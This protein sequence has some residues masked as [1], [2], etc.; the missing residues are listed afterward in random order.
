MRYP[1]RLQRLHGFLKKLRIPFKVT[2]IFMGIASTVWFLVR[3]IPK[4]TRATYPCMQAAAP[5]MSGFIVYLI[6]LFSSAMAFKLLKKNIRRL[7]FIPA[8]L[9]LLIA[10]VSSVIFIGNNTSKARADI[11]IPVAIHTPNEPMGE[12][13]GIFPGRVVWAWD[14]DATN[15]NCSPTTFGDGWWLPK[16]NDQA[17]V[18]EMLEKSILKLTGESTIASAWEVLFKYFNKKK[19][20]QEVS[21]T[22]GEKILI[23]TNVTSAWS[24]GTSWAMMNSDFSKNFN[25][26]Y[27]IA[28]TSPH[29]VLAI[30]RQLV[31][32][33]G[34]K[35]EDISIGDPMKNIYQS[36]YTMWHDEFP[37]IH[38]LGNYYH[39]DFTELDLLN[40]GR[41]PV[42]EGEYPSIFY[43]DD[44]TITAGSDHFYTVTEDANYMINIPT[45]KAHA[46]AG[47]TLTAKNHFGSHTRSSAGHLH[48]GL[49]APDEGPPVRTDYGMYRT[50]V[51]L[52]GHPLLGG[53]T[54]L[55]IVD[56][57]YA[58]SEAIDPPTKWD[59]APFNGDWTSSVFLSQDQVAL[60]SVCFDFL[61]TEYDGTGGKVNYPNYPAVDDYLM[62]AADPA[63]WPEGIDYMPDGEN[64]ISSLGAHEHWNN[65]QDKAYTR[66]LGGNEGIQL[67]S[68]PGNLVTSDAG[69]TEVDLNNCGFMALYPNPFSESVNL[70]FNISGLASVSLEIHNLAGQLVYQAPDKT[71]GPGQYTLTWNGT[72]GNG[73]EVPGG[74]YIARLKVVTSSGVKIDSERLGFLK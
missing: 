62:Q 59:M 19:H 60:E 45:L 51:D 16:N 55:F 57:M 74:M 3:V 25:N 65:A 72:N 69:A 41:T 50:Q 44:Q 43:S 21:Y 14:A 70:P 48:P 2:F 64:V 67:L 46:R 32:E 15:E 36:H 38:Y 28:E 18:D 6:T 7:R 31:N 30:L 8:A 49:V 29:V 61:R 68:I 11:D 13:V 24:A 12:G 71:Y 53:N 4:P 26:Y 39:Y 5:V 35:E 52:M 9:A 1:E 42:V 54:M 22:P 58:G 33:A 73:Q 27:G 23:K 20:D 66:N 37:D 56:A 10:T 47:I 63:N 17:V 40:Y 34:V